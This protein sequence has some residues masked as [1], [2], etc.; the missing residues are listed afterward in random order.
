MRLRNR[1]TKNL[2]DNE[3]GQKIADLLVEKLDDKNEVIDTC[4]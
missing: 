4:T 2:N 1:I 3:R